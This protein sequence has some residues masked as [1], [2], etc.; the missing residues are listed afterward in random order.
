MA[1]KCPLYG[2]DLRPVPPQGTSQTC[3]SCKK[4]DP[5]N[6]LRCGREF[7]CVHC[8]HLDHADHIAS[9]EIEARARRMGDTV[10]KSTRSLQAGARGQTS[11]AR[12]RAA[13]AAAP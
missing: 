5:R 1:Y 10:T 3:P 2:S 6:R 9:I 11:G 12:M 4:R 7:A 13:L 8:G